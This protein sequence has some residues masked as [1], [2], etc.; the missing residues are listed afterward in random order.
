MIETV[1]AAR[2]LGEITEFEAVLNG[3]V[4]FMLDRLSHGA[5]FDAALA[6]ARAAGF[7]EEDPSADLEGHD[8]AAKLRI[9]AVRSLRRGARTTKEIPRPVLN[10]DVVAR[11]GGCGTLRQVGYCVREDD[12]VDAWVNLELTLEARLFRTLRG[13]RNA[14]S[15]GVEGWPCS[16]LGKDMARAVGR[17]RKAC[18]RTGRAGALEGRL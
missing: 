10:A 14:A 9:L 8:A 17:R 18:S 3:T 13:E 12:A 2:A 5:A 7:A 11:H 1:R 15:R 6:D 16:R 4:N